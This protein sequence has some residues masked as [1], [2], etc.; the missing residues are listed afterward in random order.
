MY[1]I[2]HVIP[3]QNLYPPQNGG[4]LRCFHLLQQLAKNAE[5]DV[6]SFQPSKELIKAAQFLGNV[7]FYNPDSVYDK[8]VF[9][10]L[11]ER[12]A[13]AL[14]Y[15]WYNKTIIGPATYSFI[16]FRHIIDYLHHHKQ[17][18]FIVLEHL[19]TLSLS[20]YI[21]QKWSQAK[22]IYDAHNIDHKL[23]V[24][25]TKAWFK[26][27]YKEQS[28]YK[29]ADH[30]WVCSDED[31]TDLLQLNNNKIKV[32]TIPNGVDISNE[33]QQDKYGCYYNV[34][35]CGS[36]NYQPNIAGLQ[37]FSDF[38]WPII[39]EKVP[40]VS[41]T[42]IGKGYRSG[43]ESLI[44]HENVRFVGEVET[45]IPFYMDA[46]ISI[47]PLLEGSGTRLKA[48]EAM[49]LGN[50]LVGTAIGL[51]GINLI[52]GKHALIESDPVRFAH[53]IIDLITNPTKGDELR[54]N[55]RRLIDNC[56]AWDVIGK[57][58]NKFLLNE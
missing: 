4:A 56:Y 51:E 46:F 47:V 11:P 25:D 30:V 18:D 21:R 34:I 38:I 48:L 19:D 53:A 20:N 24:K 43:L 6:L 41:L 39:V 9:N 28:I 14:N 16:K 35:F 32:T 49:S 27:R 29:Y 50:P 12:V 52:N 8:S 57:D 22:I 31:R 26:I 33:F 40:N 17:Y 15:R 1:R 44:E 45:V 55:A 58:I 36:L 10:F 37:W 42:I 13:S 7:N 2:L 5:V 54:A 23:I 3:Y